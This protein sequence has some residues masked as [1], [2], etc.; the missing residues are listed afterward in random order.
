MKMQYTR[1]YFFNENFFF[2]DY[3]KVKDIVGYA[4]RN[5]DRLGRNGMRNYS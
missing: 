5:P 3:L 4:K 1:Y 2:K